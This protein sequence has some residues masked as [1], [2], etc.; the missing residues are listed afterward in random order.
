MIEY[1]KQITFILVVDGEDLPNE[2]SDEL[3]R[4]LIDNLNISDDVNDMFLDSIQSSISG[5]IV[6]YRFLNTSK[7]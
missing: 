1:R 2:L 4:S 7:I 5:D 6:S 3:V